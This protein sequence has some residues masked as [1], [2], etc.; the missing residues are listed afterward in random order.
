MW[1][2]LLTPGPFE[3]PPPLLQSPGKGEGDRDLL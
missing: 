3:P 1:N 2:L